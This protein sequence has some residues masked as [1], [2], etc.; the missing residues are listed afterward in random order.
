MIGMRFLMRMIAYSLLAVLMLSMVATQP[1]LA[2]DTLQVQL[3]DTGLGVVKQDSPVAPLTYDVNG[4]GDGSAHASGTLDSQG[5]DTYSIEVRE[6]VELSVR[7]T[8]DDGNLVLTVV[9]AD[10][11]PLLTDHAGA[12]S[13]DQAVPVSQ[14]YR[15]TVINFGPTAA[16]YE[17]AVDVGE[18]EGDEGADPDDGGGSVALPH[19]DSSRIQRTRYFG[20]A[21]AVRTRL[22]WQRRAVPEGR[23]RK[24]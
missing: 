18:Q 6:G 14:V 8:P 7:V 17:I 24:P 5:M 15:L 23:G 9:G 11:D 4:D 13:F 20:G 22:N 12:S 3:N 1:L 2:A 19:A 16:Q 10:G 21:Q